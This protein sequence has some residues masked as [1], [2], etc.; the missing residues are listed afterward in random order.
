MLKFPEFNPVIFQITD[1]LQIRWYGVMYLV[2]FAL[3]WALLRYK[4][5]RLPDWQTNDYASDLIFYA[6]IGVILG[7]RLGYMLFYA[8][9]DLLKDPLLILRIWEGGMSFHGGLI[10]VC[11]AICLFAK[12][13]KQ[14]ILLV[15]DVVS[16]CVPIALAAGRLGNF[17]NSELWGKVTDVPWGMVFPNGGP[18]PR[19]PSQI[20]AILLEGFLLLTIM[21]IY[22]R[23]PRKPGCVSGVFL[24]GYAAIRIFEEFFR[25]PDPQYG[26]LFAG[27]VT[28][29]QILCVPMFLVGAALFYCANKC[30]LGHKHCHS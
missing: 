30:S 23:K 27:W 1:T 15:G 25:Q 24:M 2:G 18:L 13:T 29:G 12:N 28:M 26:Y 11:V 10:G 21:L 14:S 6:A 20:Y 3:S 9:P 22:S 7:G 4:T 8:F 19:H 17:I 16:P 5:R